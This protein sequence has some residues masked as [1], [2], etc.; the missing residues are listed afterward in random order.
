MII[1]AHIKYDTKTVSVRQANIGKLNFYRNHNTKC[2]T[3]S[4]I[5]HKQVA[6]YGVMTICNA[7][8]ICLFRK[9]VANCDRRQNYNNGQPHSF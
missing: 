7:A 4:K 1:S 8:G 3:V 2:E 6:I 9:S 5:P